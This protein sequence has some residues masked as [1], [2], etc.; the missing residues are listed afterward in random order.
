MELVIT[1]RCFEVLLV[2]LSPI[3]PS[4]HSMELNLEAM[5][6]V[7]VTMLPLRSRWMVRETPLDYDFSVAHQGLRELTND[8]VGSGEKEWF[9]LLIFGRCDYG[10]GGG[11]THWLGIH[12]TGGGIYGL[13]LEREDAMFLFN[14]S[15]NRFVHTFVLLGEYLG[16]GVNLPADVAVRAHNID[17]ETYCSSEWRL[18]IDYL[19][20]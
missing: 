13:D 16:K 10:D 4:V 17:L 14:S 2:K 19:A 15:I 6:L 8:M 11:A 5:R 9:D 20:G 3:C 18:L 1:R 12:K 7:I